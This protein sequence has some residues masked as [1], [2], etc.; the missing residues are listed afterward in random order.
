MS[1]LN[2][3]NPVSA[4]AIM[5]VLG[6]AA[7]AQTATTPPAAETPAVEAPASN[8]P[9]TAEPVTITADTMPDVLK[10]LDLTD[11]DIDAGRRGG[12]KIEGEMADGTEIEAM[13]DP[14]GN[15]R[16]VRADD[17]K[18]LPQSVIDALLPE[19]VRASSILAEMATIGGI[20]VMGDGVMVGG[21]DAA[22]ENVRAAF[23][24]DG[25]LIRFGRGDDMRGHG[26]KGDHG[27]HM[28]GHGGKDGKDMRRG[29][30][31]GGGHD[32]GS[33]SGQ[34]PAMLDDAAAT[35]A[36]ADAGYT[37]LGAITRDGSRTMVEAV[38][39]SGETVTVEL[40]PNAQVVRETAR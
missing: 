26:G 33:R 3:R 27:K 19:A 8:T 38:N 18:P 6:G 35:T 12:T 36:L 9:A 23:A 37:A 10:V 17:D 15:L 13:I 22:G 24:N 1:R 16:M 4:L 20:G 28:R 21:K 25:T 31:R 32:R 30:R 29:D 39:P 11:L 7:F 34:A 40:N 2:L 14:A 5:A